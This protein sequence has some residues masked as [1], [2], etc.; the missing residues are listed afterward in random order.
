MNEE[1]NW[2]EGVMERLGA[3]ADR[4]GKSTEEAQVEF[5]AWLAKEFNVTDA[6]EE[7]EYLLVEW[8]EMFV[9]ETRNLGGGS[10]GGGRETT[11]FVGHIIGLDEYMNDLRGRQYE[12]ATNLWRQ[13]SDRAIDEG[14]IGVLSAR[15]GVWHVNGEATSERVDGDNL[16]WFGFEFDNHVLCLLNRNANSNNKGKP[17]APSSMMRTLYFLGN[18]EN[19]F[20]NSIKLWRVGLTGKSME[21]EY[22]IGQ[23]CR[24][25]VVG[26]NAEKGNAYTNRDFHSTV[27]Y[28]DDFVSEDMRRELQGDRFLVNDQVHNLYTDLDELVETYEARKEPNP[29]TGGFYGPTILTKGYVS[30][31]N[32][33]PNESEYDQ[34]GRSFR[35]NV[36]SHALQVRY[37]R[38]SPLSETTV[39]VPGRTYDDCH[40]FE[41]KN[42]N[43][44]WQNY[45]ERTQVIICAKLR[46]REFNG[47]NVPSL[48]AYG[49]YVPPRTAR[50]AATGGDTTLGQFGGE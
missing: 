36:T 9:I 50:P 25:K 11:D 18:E 14:Y 7:D 10:G 16:P 45:A 32:L 22:Q 17:M 27:V 3:Y 30:R 5:S 47:N 23:P 39:W 41:F 8:S 44:E 35:L 29:N 1:W 37:G 19:L 34:T 42:G 31:M 48:T 38:D 33:E 15:N 26:V 28:T 46:M 43:G 2:P 6:R 24:I 12:T 20:E 4:T 49:V 21:S 40:P 13:N